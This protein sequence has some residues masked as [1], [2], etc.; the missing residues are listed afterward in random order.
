MSE[1]ALLLRARMRL[2]M[3]QA[4]CIKFIARELEVTPRTVQRWLSG[5]RQMA[6][7]YLKLLRAILEARSAD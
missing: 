2:G 7:G 3:S 5:S 1:L 6:P 4:E